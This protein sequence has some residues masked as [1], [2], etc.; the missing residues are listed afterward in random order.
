[1]ARP[2]RSS[3]VRTARWSLSRYLDDSRDGGNAL[4]LT[5]P[6]VLAYQVG[7]LFR[8]GAARNAADAWISD[9][10]LKVGPFA[11]LAVNLSLCAVFL[12]VAL[13]RRRPASPVGLI[14]PVL[15]ESAIYAALLAPAVHA[16][17][18]RRLS[19][20]GGGPGAAAFDAVV[21]AV[22]AGFYEE[23]IFR[24]G[25]LAGTYW[26]CRRLL[27]IG[28]RGAV[29]VALAAS[30]VAFSLFHHLGSGAEPFTAGAFLFRAAAGALLGVLFVLR[31]FG[32]VCY[33]HALYNLM[34][35]F[36]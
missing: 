23:L 9:L 28:P 4:L 36:G 20:D 2:S 35:R 22:G 29:G 24:L 31:G 5:L 32:V 21:L 6:L 33:T 25:A 19:A 26:I 10:L 30:S 15:A 3:D 34:V 1:M 27:F 16:L 8:R 18:G 11:T 14:L 17:S 7:L 13:R 12:L